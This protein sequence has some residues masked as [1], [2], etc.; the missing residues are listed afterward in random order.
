MLLDAVSDPVPE[1][2]WPWIASVLAALARRYGLVQQ[3]I[4]LAD[5]FKRLS[6]I[7]YTLRFSLRLSADLPTK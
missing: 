7:L 1:W 4:P 2:L 6:Y 5:G 3:P